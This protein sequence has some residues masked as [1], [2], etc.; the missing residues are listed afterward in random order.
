MIKLHIDGS[1]LERIRQLTGVTNYHF[2]GFS[3]DLQEGLLTD[4]L[5]QESIYN[6]DYYNWL[7]SNL[8]INYSNATFK[9][10][11]GKLV[12]LGEFPDGLA[13]ENGFIK[14]AI[15]PI[16]EVFGDNPAEL[17]TVAKRFGG[18][19]LNFGDGSAEIPSLKGIP[20]TYIIYGSDEFPSSANILFDQSAINYMPLEALVVLGEITTARLIEAKN[21]L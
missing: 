15:T 11:N 13:R 6:N 8:L 2:L 9:P 12:K 20:L 16:A 21:L 17:P 18:K 5:R 19:V 3:V 1:P 10:V 4:D 14:T 7:L